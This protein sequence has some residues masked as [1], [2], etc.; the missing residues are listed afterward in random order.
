[1]GMGS[2]PKVPEPQKPAPLPTAVNPEVLAARQRHI[3]DAKR[4]AALSETLLTSPSG[5]IDS[6]AIPKKTL[7]GA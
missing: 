5:L 4:R 6:N 7:L 3:S 2:S 1:M